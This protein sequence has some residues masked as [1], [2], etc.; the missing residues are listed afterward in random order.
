MNKKPRKPSTK[1]ADDEED[2]DDDPKDGEDDDD[3][4]NG[5]MPWE[6][7]LRQWEIEEKQGDESSRFTLFR[8]HASNKTNERVFEWFDEV[9]TGHEIGLRFGGGQYIAY[10]NLP[11][12]KDKKPRFRCRRFIL[13]DTYTA[14]KRKRDAAEAA[15]L[16]APQGQAAAGMMGNPLEMVAMVINQIVV[17]LMAARPQQADPFAAYKGFSEA[18]LQ[19]TEASARSSIQLTRELQKELT[20]GKPAQAES[21]EDKATEDDFKSFL[22]D[23]LKEY[24]PTIIEAGA[25]K[26]KSIASAIKKDEVFQALSQDQNLFSRVLGLIAKDPEIDK[27]VAQKVLGKLAKMNIGIKVPL[28][29]LT[30]PAAPAAPAASAAVPTSSTGEAG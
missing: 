11:R 3:P 5:Y 20:L 27:D 2:D 23:I 17:P 1:P 10:L 9:P 4:Q 19:I 30:T 7:D 22:K 16:N 6:E 26:M 18:M 25:L 24:G 15:G 12:G 28:G 21:A 13:A 14:E 8:R 29:V